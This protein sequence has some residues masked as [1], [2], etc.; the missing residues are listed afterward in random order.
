M[1]DLLLVIAEDGSPLAPEWL[2]RMGRGVFRC[3]VPDWQEPLYN[4]KRF[5][6]DVAV[7]KSPEEG[8]PR[9]MT[10]TEIAV[11][12]G[13][14]RQTIHTYRRAGVFPRP[15]AGEGS[16]RAKFRA[17]EVAAFFAANPKQPG[18][19]TDLA[20]PADE[21]ETVSTTDSAVAV[22]APWLPAVE[23][24]EYGLRLRD[25]TL[26][27]FDSR[28]ERDAR[29]AELEDAEWEVTPLVRRKRMQETKW[30]EE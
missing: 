26:L 18:K 19:R 12:H 21:G 30:A 8:S 16:T 10:T 17:D 2:L 14:S 28:E 22:E 20:S 9:L 6:K 25:K 23:T 3:A 24:T 29:R 1:A 27:T 11:E 15:V 5:G 4:V 7:P 13:V